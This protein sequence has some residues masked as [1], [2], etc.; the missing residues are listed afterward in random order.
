MKALKRSQ[1]L[2]AKEMEGEQAAG[3]AICDLIF[4]LASNTDAHCKVPLSLAPR[5]NLNTKKP[6]QSGDSSNP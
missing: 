2:H 6:R 4:T 1:L 3:S 5:L